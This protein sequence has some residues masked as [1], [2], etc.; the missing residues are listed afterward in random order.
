[1]RVWQ[2]SVSVCPLANLAFLTG[3]NLSSHTLLWLWSQ[4]VLFDD[5]NG[6]L[7]YVFLRD[8]FRIGSYL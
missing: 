6:P 7:V 8:L 3:A 1:M 5:H 2:L 4:W